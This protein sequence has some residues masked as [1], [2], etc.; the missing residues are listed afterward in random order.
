MGVGVGV[1]KT[2]ADRLAKIAVLVI[3]GVVLAL[4]AGYVGVLWH[5][6]RHASAPDRAVSF[7]EPPDR[8][9][10]SRG[11]P[12]FRVARA[13]DRFE[14]V[15]DAGRVVVLRGVQMAD[16]ALRPPYRPVALGDDDAFRQMRSW[17]FNAVR[18]AVPWEALEPTPRA[19]NLEHVRYLQW[20]LDTAH[21]AGMVVVLDNPLHGASRCL[22]GAGAPTWAHRPGLVSEEA[23]AS[24]CED[25]EDRWL[26]DWP[27][28]LRWWADFYD[29]A[30]TPDDIS[31]Q[32]HLIRAFVK[33]AEV[34]QDQPALLG[35]GLAG[36]AP[37]EHGGL[38]AWLYPGRTPCDEALS[39]FYR[40]F[41]RALRAV[42]ADAMIFFEE[43]VRW[44][45]DAPSWVEVQ[46]PPVDGVVWSV[47]ARLG[48]TASPDARFDLHAL[49][50]RA[51]AQYHAP[52]VLCD[53]EVPRTRDAAE[54][55]VAVL[56]GARVSVFLSD[57]ARAEGACNPRNLVVAEGCGTARAGTPRCATGA[58]VRPAPLRIGGVGAAWGL[59]RAPEAE[60]V[61]APDIFTLTFRQADT[62]ADTWIFVPRR[63][64]YGEDPATEAPEF[65]VD[66]S[67]GPWRWAEW[68]DQ[69]LVWTPDPAV[70]EHRLVLKP[71]GGRPAPGN[72]VGE[73]ADGAPPP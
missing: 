8:P 56:E 4:A 20:F 2:N 52:L 48:G 7:L 55:L 10:P 35:Y 25:P 51:T 22:G 54:R 27:R 60:E 49:V 31:L 38:A 62:Y 15:D 13:G 70:E 73:C 18:L 23:A 68:D 9:A 66:V 50:G 42:D 72:G 21:A 43:P 26:P 24:G 34:L 11:V 41:A 69:V 47:P 6:A 12:L 28:R 57:Y 61:A 16:A 30:W 67:D 37:C 5:L 71:W 29:G 17:G 53:V 33:L 46:A 36:G 14:V 44:D 45:E 40:R 32:D 59:A 65:T 39:D 58:F 19:L 64:L 3:I 1:R 63:L